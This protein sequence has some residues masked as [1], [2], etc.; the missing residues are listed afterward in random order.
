[1]TISTAEDGIFYIFGVYNKD[2]LVVELTQ[3]ELIFKR[4]ICKTSNGQARLSLPRA[5]AEALGGAAV[6]L[7]WRGGSVVITAWPEER[8]A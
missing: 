6:V 4:K 8:A 5:I 1:M 7:V 2:K 3:K